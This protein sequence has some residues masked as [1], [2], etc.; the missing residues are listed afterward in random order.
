MEDERREAAIA[1][2]SVLQPNFKSGSVRRD[3][4]NKFKELHRRRLQIKSNS[5]IQKNSKANASG[6]GKAHG[7]K[8][9]AK[10]SKVK[11]TSVMI[12]DSSVSTSKGNN[13]K[14]ISSLQQ[15]KASASLVSKKH[16]KLHW[17]LDTKERWERKANM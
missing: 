13:T 2:A 1:A 10:A 4:L 9:G 15:D 6:A 14:D 7:E 17:G 3:Q 16:P 5:K 8:L 11:D 12:D